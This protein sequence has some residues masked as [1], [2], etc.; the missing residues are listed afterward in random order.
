MWTQDSLRGTPPP[1]KRRYMSTISYWLGMQAV[2]QLTEPWLKVGGQREGPMAG[3]Q[4]RRRARARFA[5]CD[6]RGREFGPI[7]TNFGEVLPPPP[8]G[9]G[10]RIGIACH[11]FGETYGG[12]ADSTL[13]RRRPGVGDLV[14]ILTLVA[15]CARVRAARMACASAQRAQRAGRRPVLA[16][17]AARWRR[18]PGLRVLAMAAFT[19]RSREKCIHGVARF[20]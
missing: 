17:R 8:V 10:G 3:G 9:R 2:L 16:L 20:F 4:A 19:G 12:D 18:A 1:L 11:A 15:A 6:R 5:K 14:S 7:R 13:T